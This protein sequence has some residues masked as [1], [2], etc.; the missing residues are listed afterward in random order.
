[1]PC[2]GAGRAAER[3]DLGTHQR[4]GHLPHQLAQHIHIAVGDQLAHLL[5]SVHRELGHR[6]SPFI[7]LLG[8]EEDDLGGRLPSTGRPRLLLISSYTTCWD[9]NTGFLAWSD[10][11]SD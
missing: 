8:L 4:L 5:Q 1:M 9:A 6:V 2:G 7:V 3:V 11:H 10:P